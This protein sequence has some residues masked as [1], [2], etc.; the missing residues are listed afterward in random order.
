MPQPQPQPLS[1]LSSA[2]SLR[3]VLVDLSLTVEPDAPALARA[4]RIA[5]THGLEL[6]LAQL[7]HER[8]LP[9]RPTLVVL[10]KATRGLARRSTAER[11]HDVT[12]GA[13][14]LVRN[15]VV[16]PY[17]HVVIGANLDSAFDDVAAAV[18]FVAPGA[19]LEAIHAF[20]SPFEP[21]LAFHGVATTAMEDYRRD[22]ARRVRERLEALLG[23]SALGRASLRLEPGEAATVLARAPADV[24]VVVQRGRSWLRHAVFGS[25]TRAVLKDGLADVLVV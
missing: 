6:G 24:L 9:A 17:D 23:R 7:D 19:R 14:L 18:R 12:G 16:G 1:A 4:R 5:D 10:G 15:P 21:M 2:T 3:T 11:I 13:V 25:V 8:S 20:A 22:R